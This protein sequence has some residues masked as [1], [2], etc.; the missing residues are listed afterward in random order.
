M[1]NA[2]TKLSMKDVGLA[3]KITNVHRPLFGK[4]VNEI[5]ALFML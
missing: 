2:P 1:E 5:Q 3:D 4:K